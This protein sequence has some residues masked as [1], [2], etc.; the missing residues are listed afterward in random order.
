M[1][2]FA[3]NVGKGCLKVPKLNIYCYFCDMKLVFAT[4]NKGKLREAAEILGPDY[5]IVSPEELGIFDE[6]EESG[7]TFQENSIIKARYFYEKTGI[8]C[9]A[10]DSGL[11]VDALGGAPGIYSARY[12]SLGGTRDDRPI[13]MFPAVD[14]NFDENIAKVYRELDRVREEARKAGDPEPAMTARFRCVATLIT[15]GEEHVFDGTI[16]GIIAPESSGSGGFGYDPIFIPTEDPDPRFP[17]EKGLT[18]AQVSEEAKNA[19][20]HR[21]KA[22]RLMAEWLRK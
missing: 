20:S 22:L 18:L 2:F 15:G 9:F 17:F 3:F 10:D 4:G 5:E 8:D 7:A 19:I 13:A 11:E 12:A 6:V 1:R 16:E 21:G 14:H